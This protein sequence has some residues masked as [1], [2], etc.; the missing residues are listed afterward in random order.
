MSRHPSSRSVRSTGAAATPW[1]CFCKADAQRPSMTARHPGR[2][3]P[4]FAPLAVRHRVIVAFVPVET[5]Q[6]MAAG[7][8]LLR[9][10][11]MLG[12]RLQSTRSRSTTRQ[13]RARIVR[14][15]STSS[16]PFLVFAAFIATRRHSPDAGP[17]PSVL[18][19]CLFLGGEKLF[20]ALQRVAFQGCQIRVP[21]VKV[22]DG[23]GAKRRR[24]FDGGH[25]GRRVSGSL[26][27]HKRG[28][29]L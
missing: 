26:E 7:A 25:R 10:A 17:R 24:L 15:S 23:L 16:Q 27:E 4:M 13:W 6:V 2:R 11:M 21:R 29:D 22:T 3:R 1:I 8:L 14:S 5:H 19:R 9:R 28:L 18:E 12:P 20:I